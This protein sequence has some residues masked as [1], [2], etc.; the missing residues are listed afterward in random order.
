MRLEVLTGVFRGSNLQ[1]AFLFF[2]GLIAPQ[3]QAKSPLNILAREIHYNLDDPE[4]LPWW[5]SLEPAHVGNILHSL[6]TLHFFPP[7]PRKYYSSLPHFAR[8]EH[9]AHEVSVFLEK[10]RKQ[11]LGY[12]QVDHV[13]YWA[14]YSQSWAQRAILSVRSAT[15]NSDIIAEKFEV[16]DD[17]IH[18]RKIQKMPPRRIIPLSIVFLTTVESP[19]QLRLLG[20]VFQSILDMEKA[21]PGTVS[22]CVLVADHV[23]ISQWKT[24]DVHVLLS[25]LHVGSSLKSCPWEAEQRE[26]VCV[27]QPGVTFSPGIAEEI[28]FWTTKNR[29]AY[30]PEGLFCSPFVLVLLLVVVVLVVFVICSAKFANWVYFLQGFLVDEL[31][32]EDLCDETASEL[33]NYPKSWKK[34][35]LSLIA[36]YREDFLAVGGMAEISGRAENDRLL[37]QSASSFLL[38][39]IFF[40]IRA[41]GGL[42]VVRPSDSSVFIKGPAAHSVPPFLAKEFGWNLQR[43]FEEQRQAPW[44]LKLAATFSTSLPVYQDYAPEYAFDEEDGT[45]FWASRSLDPGDFFQLDLEVPFLCKEV[46]IFTG[47]RTQVSILFLCVFPLFFVVFQPI[48]LKAVQL[49]PARFL[50]DLAGRKEVQKGVCFS[51]HQ[52]RRGPRDVQGEASHQIVENCGC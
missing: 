49:A 10:E 42:S 36:L 18:T 21:R 26:V 37:I 47:A 51:E 44:R 30:S 40:R 50:G 1:G 7:F 14:D 8:L 23:D 12:F 33:C 22:L 4:S 9:Y 32:L 39:D 13:E 31:P 19:E 34:D 2:F 27:F 11:P 17:Y 52:Q 48:P 43:S 24:T 41:Y 5:L 25:H 46:R 20:E 28:E 38:T 16:W 45:Y 15:G 29:R 6:S 3:P 35:S